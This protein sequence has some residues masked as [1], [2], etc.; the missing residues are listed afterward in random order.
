MIKAVTMLRQVQP[1]SERKFDKG[2]SERSG[3]TG[4]KDGYGIM[5]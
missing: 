4:K 5:D 2:R 1:G 3:S